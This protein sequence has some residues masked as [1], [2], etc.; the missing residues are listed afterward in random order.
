MQKI[1]CQLEMYKGSCL[2]TERHPSR[3]EEKE[4]EKKRGGGHKHL[5]KSICLDKT[6]INFADLRRGR[7]NKF[8]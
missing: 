7:H 6:T 2:H 4:V 3:I 8:C 5:I 1:K